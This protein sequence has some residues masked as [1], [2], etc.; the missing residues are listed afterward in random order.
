MA[1]EKEGH[2]HFVLQFLEECKDAGLHTHIQRRDAFIGDD[3]IG[4]QGEGAGDADPLALPAGKF[5]GI[6][7]ELIFRQADAADQVGGA[8]ALIGGAPMPW[9][10]SGSAIRSPTRMRGSSAAIG[11]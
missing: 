9:M 6:A 2:A 1:D 3:Q 11:S 10:T 4:L 7:V 8:G 5:V